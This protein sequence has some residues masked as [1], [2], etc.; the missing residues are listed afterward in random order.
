MAVSSCVESTSELSF[1]ETKFE[2]DGNSSVINP[3]DNSDEDGVRLYVNNCSSCHGDLNHSDKLGATKEEISRAIET[4]S[5]MQSLKS[6]TSQ[7]VA[8]I[9]KELSFQSP[10]MNY[11]SPAN[12][13]NFNSSTKNIDLKVDTNEVATCRYS[14]TNR[15]Y[16]KMMN[17]MIPSS[18]GKN[19]KVTLSVVEGNTYTYY[20]Q[21]ADKF[22]N[23]T[24]VALKT[25]FD[26][27]AASTPDTT[28]PI[29]SGFYPRHNSEL[30]PGTTS[31]DM[32]FSTNEASV[33]HYSSDRNKNYDQMLKPT[34]TGEL[35]HTQKI[36][37]LKN[38]DVKT[39]Y[40]M[41]RDRSYNFNS[42]VTLTF[43][44]RDLVLDGV[45]LYQENCMG[46]HGP[47]ANSTKKNRSVLQI[48]N[49]ISQNSTMS[50]ES[51]LKLLIDSQIESISDTLSIQNGGNGSNQNTSVEQKYVIGTQSFVASKFKAIF[52]NDN[53]N[54]DDDKISRHIDKLISNNSNSDFG[55]AC[56]RHSP[57]CKGGSEEIRVNGKMLPDATAARR[58]YII[59]ACRLV[60]NEDRA[61][62]NALRRGGLNTSS[63]GMSSTNIEL[64]YDVFFPGLNIDSITRDSLRNIYN[65]SKSEG[66]SNT[67]SWRM[68]MSVMCE[69]SLYELY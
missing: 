20:I 40:F 56:S 58:A 60:L 26:I 64:L 67:S 3:T 49:A 25:I 6:L 45:A 13:S 44:V 47:L 55:G 14:S 33:C 22:L 19:H 34:T 52:V 31:V 36:D 4:N 63:S 11:L 51:Y 30:E 38:G 18:S 59:R 61:V 24:I 21:C 17:N 23:P 12:N 48:K 5:S 39:Y 15:S 41:C 2:D 68:V 62:S 16:D 28:A 9:E 43:K 50:K 42:R 46:C 27:D 53:P 37:G 65:Q 57:D 8:K 32:S 1:E 35:F 7:Q 69:S 10:Q 66:L 29:L 54:S